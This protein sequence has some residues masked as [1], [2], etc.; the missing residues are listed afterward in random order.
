MR[1]DSVGD[2]LPDCCRRNG[3]YATGKAVLPGA[4]SASNDEDVTIQPT[5]PHSVYEQTL[6][7]A[8]GGRRITAGLSVL[9][10]AGKGAFSRVWLPREIVRDAERLAAHEFTAE[11]VAVREIDIARQYGNV[12]IYD[13]DVTRLMRTLRDH[14]RMTDDGYRLAIVTMGCYEPGAAHGDELQIFD[15]ELRDRVQQI[16][17]I[18]WDVE[19]GAQLSDALTRQLW[20]KGWSDRRLFPDI[21]LNLAGLDLFYRG[22]SWRAPHPAKKLNYELTR[23]FLDIVGSLRAK[24]FHS[25]Q[26]MFG[27]ELPEA[28]NRNQWIY[29]APEDEKIWLLNSCVRDVFGKFDIHAGGGIGIQPTTM[30]LPAYRHRQSVQKTAL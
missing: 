20:F 30:H 6:R 19:R 7:P 15:Q 17:S 21:G 2:N 5:F 22:K 26:A 11:W 24:H 13:M 9:N 16:V 29:L 27:I 14:A 25:D 18:L 10:R 23:K 4:A 1:T 28:N 3:F 12:M 8:T